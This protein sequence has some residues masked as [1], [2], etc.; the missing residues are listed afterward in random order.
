[1]RA[2]IFLAGLVCLISPVQVMGQGDPLMKNKEGEK[3]PSIRDKFGNPK[4]SRNTP[5][6]GRTFDEW[7]TIIKTS[8]DEGL[9]TEAIQAVQ[10]YGADTAIEV[11]P[12][13]T[14]MLRRHGVRRQLDTSIRSHAI[15]AVGNIL[16]N[17]KEPDLKQINDA[18]V[19][20]KRMLRDPEDHVRFKTALAIAQ[21]GPD[22]ASLAQYLCNTTIRDPR[23][24]EIRYAATLALGSIGVDK[25]NGPNIWSLRGLAYAAEY[26]TSAEVRVTAVRAI[27]YLG[28]PK[29]E[30]M[31]LRKS[32]RDALL[33]AISD[34]HVPVRIWANMALMNLD[35]ESDPD[36]VEAIGNLLDYKERNVRFQAAHAL[37]ILGVES[38][39][40]VN[41]LIEALQDEDP[42]VV[43]QVMV[44]LGSLKGHGRPALEKLN[45]IEKGKDS[46]GVY[47]WPW[48]YRRVAKQTIAA[49]E[50]REMK[51]GKK[52][53]NQTSEENNSK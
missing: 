46:K 22:A 18:L 39:S 38:K 8:R 2:F 43:L 16:S 45:S 1:M 3:E 9:V 4:E 34:K 6:D 30:D 19:Q 31:A 26:D 10:L 27:T 47:L 48:L 23:T 49:I 12:R 17:T 52:K 51:D 11:I 20:F 32:L 53:G 14:G 28:P 37:A 7:V 36:R 40:Q 33:N 29:G 41:N 21:L 44:A 5:V 35:G 24:W 50:G 13:L 25:K 15:A 42:E